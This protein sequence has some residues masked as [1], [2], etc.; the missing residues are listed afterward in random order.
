MSYSL[1][2][3][4]SNNSFYSLKL[5]VLVLV[6]RYTYTFHRLLCGDDDLR[7]RWSCWSLS[8]MYFLEFGS[9]ATAISGTGYYNYTYNNNLSFHEYS[10]LP[11]TNRHTWI[12][13]TPSQLKKPRYV[14]LAF[15]KNRENGIEKNAS[16]FAQG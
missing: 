14:V 16:E 6:V 2:Y 7:P 11:T 10:I 8:P 5:S 9:A 15:K 13:K 1:L 4:F 12:L 3:F